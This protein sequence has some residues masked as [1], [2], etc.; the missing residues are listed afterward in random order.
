MLI[1]ISQS[2]QAQH[3][4]HACLATAGLQVT[5]A[6]SVALRPGQPIA[7]LTIGKSD[8]TAAYWLQSAT[9]TTDDVLRRSLAVLPRPGRSVGGSRQPPTWAL[10][11]ILFDDPVQVD[12]PAVR[13]QLQRL[14]DQVAQALQGVP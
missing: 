8:R 9:E 11:S 3:P 6:R 12:E 13:E 1:S 4:P 2:F 5:G 14:H 10:V 7:Q